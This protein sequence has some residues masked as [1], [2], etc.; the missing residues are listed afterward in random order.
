[1]KVERW[2]EDEEEEW[3]K[4]KEDGPETM[5][6][7]MRVMKSNHCPFN[8]T[9]QRLMRRV[10]RKADLCSGPG[11]TFLHG[12][13]TTNAGHKRKKKKMVWMWNGQW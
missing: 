3:R 13:K 2:A 7:K 12:K 11:P 4:K 1:M 10:I 6:N 8:E 9:K 5:W